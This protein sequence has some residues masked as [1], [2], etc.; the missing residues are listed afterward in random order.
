[1]WT[2]PGEPPGYH[3]CSVVWNDDS[4]HNGRPVFGDWTNG[5]VPAGLKIFKD[6]LYR[7]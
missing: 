3:A 5:G 4:W 6:S 2:V 1:M 7:F